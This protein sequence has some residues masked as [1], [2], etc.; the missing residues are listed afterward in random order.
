MT[1]FQEQAASFCRAI[2]CSDFQS[3]R[4]FRPQGESSLR[5][6]KCPGVQGGAH[7]GVR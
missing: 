4:S 3:A 7:G 6:R 2:A 1:I 5:E